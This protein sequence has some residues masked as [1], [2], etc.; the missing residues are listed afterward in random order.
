M[1]KLALLAVTCAAAVVATAAGAATPADT[2]APTAEVVPIDFSF[3]PPLLSAT[4]GFDVTRH[5]EGTLTIRTFV[6]S[7]GSFRRELDQYHLVET[8]AANGRMLVGRTT[9][10]IATTLLPDGSFNV[11]FVGT[12]FCLPVP[13]AGISFG[14]VGRFLL[15]FDANNT[16]IDIRQDVGDARGDFAAICAALT[17][18]AA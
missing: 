12:D 7:D 14:S 3:T 11:S 2:S 17:P 13:G 9:Q 10:N 6:D 1:R 15:V 5:V 18:V 4:C 16:L 8:L